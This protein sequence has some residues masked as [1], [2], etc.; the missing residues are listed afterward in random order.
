MTTEPESLSTKT[1]CVIVAG[2]SGMRVGGEKPK[3]FMPLRG[4]PVILHTVRAMVRMAVFCRT[5]VVVPS[6]WVE[7]TKSLLGKDT[8]L[9]EVL[10]V[11]GGARRQDSV[12]AGLGACGDCGVV[13][14]HD[15][16]RPFPPADIK[17][18]IAVA[19]NLGGVIFALPVTDSVKL[20]S[21]SLIIKTVSRDGLWAA[22]T[23][24]VFRV[25]RLVEAL[26]YCEGNGIEIT[27]D[28]SAFE[29]KDW[30]VGIM[31]GSRT[32]IKITYQEDFDLA[33]FLLSKGD[34]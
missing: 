28:A 11:A 5:I 6:D 34:Q 27:D 18:S 1:A 17:E 26:D 2:G 15:G 12:R 24:Q 19:A 23:P 32:N 9:Q 3:Q 13:A 16:A 31:P 4:E 29:H 22:Q 8:D 21:D 20:A 14:I 30:P 7:W 10:V 25:D 33:E